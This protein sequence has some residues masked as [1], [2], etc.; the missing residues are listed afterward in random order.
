VHFFSQCPHLFN[1]C[2]TSPIPL[3]VI[4]L[5][6]MLKCT[7]YGAI[8]FSEFFIVHFIFCLMH[9]TLFSNIHNSRYSYS[10]I[11]QDHADTKMKVNLQ[12][13]SKEVEWRG[14]DWIG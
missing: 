11:N 3:D 8:H 12:F 1:I 9:R 6:V 5:K 13:Y 10:A 4:A 2:P 7:A 14:M